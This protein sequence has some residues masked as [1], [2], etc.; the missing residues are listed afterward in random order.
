MSVAAGTPQVG[1]SEEEL[2]ERRM[3]R[4]R[5]EEGQ[6]GSTAVGVG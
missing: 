3:P 4:D 5:R 1:V 2:L 6:A